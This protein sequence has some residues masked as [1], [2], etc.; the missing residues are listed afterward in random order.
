MGDAAASERISRACDIFVAQTG[1]PAKDALE[2]LRELADAT[3]T[4]L[5][6]LAGMLIDGEIDFR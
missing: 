2:R 4:S 5:D 6:E 1:R 3:D